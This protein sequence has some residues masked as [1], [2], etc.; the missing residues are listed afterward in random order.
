MEIKWLTDKPNGDNIRIMSTARAEKYGITP[1]VSL[2]QG[3]AIVTEWF[4]QNKNT[5][6]QRYNVFVNH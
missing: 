6:D 5:L 2:D 1:K 3:V 4:K